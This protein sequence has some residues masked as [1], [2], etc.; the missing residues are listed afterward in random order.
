MLASPKRTLSTS[1]SASASVAVGGCGASS[2]DESVLLGHAGCTQEKYR[3]FYG[4]SA[5]AIE[6]IEF[7]MTSFLIESNIY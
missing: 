3:D 7:V 1:A 2:T 4:V 5:S 6:L